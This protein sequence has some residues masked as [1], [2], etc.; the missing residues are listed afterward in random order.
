MKAKAGDKVKIVSN[1]SVSR[2]GDLVG[3]YHYFKIGEVVEIISVSDVDYNAFG[4]NDYGEYVY[5]F[6][7]EEHIEVLEGENGAIK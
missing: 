2:R 7:N 1:E 5:Q 3:I 6:I 4:K